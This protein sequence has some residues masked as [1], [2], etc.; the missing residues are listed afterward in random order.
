MRYL[1]IDYGAKRMGMA[2]AD[3]ETGIAIPRGVMTRENDAAAIGKIVAMIGDERIGSVVIGLPLAHDGGET[4][5]SREVR[6]FA[7]EL[8]EKISVPV[9]FENEMFTTRMA[10]H[11]GV[12][13]KDID[14]ASA[15]IILQ[16]YLDRRKG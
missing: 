6:A 5:E 4:G 1:G 10:T 7:E 14:A 8:K 13:K 9:E 11:K 12:R 2:V 15:A 3:R 16:S